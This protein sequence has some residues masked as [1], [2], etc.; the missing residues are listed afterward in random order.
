M[1]QT[2]YV[3]QKARRSREYR[4]TYEAESLILMH[5]WLIDE[6]MRNEGVLPSQLAARLGKSRAYISQLLSGPTNMTLRTIAEVCFELGYRVVP[7]YE[8]IAESS[9]EV[10]YVLHD[11]TSNVAYLT[12]KRG[13]VE[14]R[15]L[16][17]IPE[18]V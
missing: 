11:R 14:H 6:I 16:D 12:P 2:S 9:A 8:Q 10:T 17:R 4:K 5:T 15:T 18:A 1:A 3:F 13:P 7:K